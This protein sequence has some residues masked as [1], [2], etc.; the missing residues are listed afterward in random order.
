[1]LLAEHLTRDLFGKCVGWREFEFAFNELTAR[2][3][4][5]ELAVQVQLLQAGVL[6]V[7]EVRAMRGLAPLEQ[8]VKAQM[9]SASG[10]NDGA[11]SN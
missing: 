5:T 11:D 9:L 10:G 1:M 6:T 2:D 7:N 8:A 3:E 4:T